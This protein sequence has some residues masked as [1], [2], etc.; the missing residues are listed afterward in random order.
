MFFISPNSIICA[1]NKHNTVFSLKSGFVLLLLLFSLLISPLRVYAVDTK[2]TEELAL[3]W[4]QR[5]SLPVETNLI[6]EWPVGPSIGAEAALLLEADTG[7]ILYSKNIDERLYP[8]SI[9]KMMTALLVVENCTMEETVTFSKEA[10]DNTEWGSSRIG[11][12]KGEELSVEECLYGLLLGSANEVAYGLAEHVGGDLETFVQ[13]M[14]DKAAKLGCSNTH[15]VNASGLPDDDHYVCARDMAIIAQAFFENDT[16]CMISGSYSYKIPATNKTDEERP[17][18]N[19]HKMIVGKQYEYEGIIGG[20]TG[21]TSTARQ[22][23]VTC[24][25]KDG[26]KLIC[27]VLKDES[28]YQFIDTKELF[29]YGFTCFKKLKIADYETRY[30]L[31]GGNFFHTNVDIMG[32]SKSILT[33][34]N[35]GYVVIPRTLDFE[36]VRV[37]VV[38]G[39][40]GSNVVANLNYYVGNNKVGTT[41]IKYAQKDQKT[42][43][44]ANIITDSSMDEQYTYESEQKTVFVTISDVVKKLFYIVGILFLIILVIAMILG[45]I[46]SAQR[47]K[48]KKRKR[49]K[50]RS[51]N[52]RRYNYKKR[53]ENKHRKEPIENSKGKKGLYTV[54]LYK[55]LSARAEDAANTEMYNE[56]YDRGPDEEYYDE[57]YYEED[58][59]YY[60]AGGSLEAG[61]YGSMDENVDESYYSDVSI[62]PDAGYQEGYNEEDMYRDYPQMQGYGVKLHPLDDPNRWEE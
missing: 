19:H 23:L 62:Y 53:S 18:E 60:P 40:G 48:M 8:A 11:I 13:M 15:F 27:I 49:Y 20:K 59:D 33:L 34:D 28:P 14:N 9:T 31:T 24:A 52:S 17:M 2:P 45:F 32:S 26:M 61:F 4:E 22:T 50:Q 47:A 12:M 6:E 44:F 36:N 30:N 55:S 7:T 51:E 21:F 35:Y 46:K 43:E 38:Y 16:L 29:D 10:I 56:I 39:Q 25:Q 58:G 57:G 54:P 3:E 37:E 41:S 5:K 1:N 42:F